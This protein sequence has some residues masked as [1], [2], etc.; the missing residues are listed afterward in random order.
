MDMV[1]PRSLHGISDFLQLVRSRYTTS[2]TVKA[3][4]L[5]LSLLQE[6]IVSC[7]VAGKPLICIEPS[8]PL[9]IPFKFRQSPPTNVKETAHVA[10]LGVYMRVCVH[11]GEL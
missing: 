1:S 5:Q 3:P 8:S 10:R 9:H 7:F 6:D 11:E 2:S 4:E